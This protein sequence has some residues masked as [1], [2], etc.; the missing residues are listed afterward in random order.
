TTR[1]KQFM[2]FLKDIFARLESARDTVLVQELR[3]D[4]TVSVSGR[5]LLD[6]I[7]KA[8]IFLANQG[9]KKGDRC[10]LLAH[11][12]NRWIA[13]D[14]SMMAEGIIVVPLY[15]RQAPAELVAMMKDSSPALLCCGDG[16]LR[17]AILQNWKEAPPRVL[18][19]EIFAK[20]KSND[21]TRDANKAEP[22]AQN[23]AQL[24]DSDT[25]TIIYTSGT[26]G[27][28][29]GV[30]L[31]SANISFMLGC[32]SRRLD[33]LMKNRAGQDRVYHYLPFAF[34]ASRI[35]L[36]T[37]LLRG[38]LVMLNTDLSKIASE[39]PTV[40]ADYFLNVPALLERMRKAVDE[41]LVK[42]GGIALRIYNRGKAAW[43]R[44][45]SGKAG[46][47]DT[48]W[49]ACANAIVFPAI[50]KKMVGPNLK[51]LISG[52]A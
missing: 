15:A 38:S 26:S 41:Q 11:N 21:L 35:A 27:E 20:G 2:S 3:E 9:L 43:L 44:K 23:K 52:S 42:K 5:E 6:L 17:D 48:I 10:A 19:E 14:F 18:F 36:F 37:Y 49:L 50:R 28:A 24:A 16:A 30:V 31:N 32:T 4:Q 33:T 39:M 1:Q 22:S 47:A 13:M 8:R 51:A 12:S 34:G 29:K 40:A 25:V 46:I 45:R 7:T